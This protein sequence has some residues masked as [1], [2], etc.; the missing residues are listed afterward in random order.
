MP[1]TIADV[2]KHKKGLSD[3]QK[4]QWVAVANSVLAK[5]IKDGG[6]DATCAPT[7][8]R[9]ANGVTGNQLFVNAS[10]NNY[11]IR[12]TMHQGRRNLIVPVVMMV[13]GV[14]NGSLGPLFHPAQEL[15]KFPDSW[16]G[17]P[18]MI[19][20]PVDDNGMNISANSPDVLEQSVG[21][22]FNAHMDGTK[23]KA[24]SYVD[25]EKLQALSPDAYTAIMNGQPLEVSIGVFTE[26]DQTPGQWNGENYT[27]IARSHRPDHLALL[28]GGIGA[29]SWNDGCGIRVN[30]KK[31]G[32][33]ESM[34][35]EKP[36]QVNEEKQLHIKSI[37]DA[38]MDQG[39]KA[40]VE[41]AQRMLDA[42]DNQTS[43]HYLED[44]NSSHVIYSKR[45]REN[46][47]KKMLKQQYEMDANGMPTLVGNPQEVKQKVEYVP[48]VHMERKS[49]NNSKGGQT[50][51]NEKKPCGQCMEKVIAIIN[52]NS[53]HFT[54][55]DREWLLTQEET[56]LDKLM[57]KEPEKKVEVNT[58]KP[59]TETVQVLSDDDKADLAW[60][61]RERKERRQ[62]MINGI[63]ANTEKDLWPEADLMTMSEAFLEKL[64]NSVVPEDG[65]GDEET[66]N[67]SLNGSSRRIEANASAVEPLYPTGVEVVENKK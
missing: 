64:Y 7:A 48:V 32:G 51:E 34:E 60:A 26:E 12:E 66:A 22:V 33:N 6:T 8:I 11:V 24:D 25:P 35:P 3:K 29:C 57:P 58:E 28:P 9:E 23:L 62:K 27:A 61:R 63:Q 39:Y 19:Q 43:S 44:M 36:V 47:G 17:I 14:H 40:M 15:G 16:N 20:H 10:N 54:A 50:M 45:S 31:E 56:I 37:I 42:M 67:Y 53:T 46:P 55:A 52:S 41:S 59:K 1:W 4:K 5:C 13:E 30:Q 38:N 18:I 21:K 2:D 65:E 49:N